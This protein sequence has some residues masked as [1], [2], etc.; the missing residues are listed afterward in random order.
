M[1]LDCSGVVTRVAS[2]VDNGL[3]IG[4]RVCGLFRGHCANRLQVD[5][6][7]M[8]RIPDGMDFMTAASLPLVFTTAYYSLVELARLLPGETVLIHCGGGG[9]G[10]AAIMLAKSLGAEVFATANSLDEQS[11][12]CKT[13]SLTLGHVFFSQDSSFVSQIMSLTG[14]QGVEVI[15]NSLA[16][17]LLQETWKCIAPFGRFVEIGKHDLDLNHNLEMEPF[18]RNVSFMSVDMI[19]IAEQRRDLLTKMLREIMLLWQQ[20]KISPVAPIIA[21]PLSDV[22]EALR[23]LQSG[24]VLGK[25]CLYPSKQD[26]V[27]VLPQKRSPKLVVSA[28][29]VL[30]GGSGG[31]G[32][33]IARLLVELGS[34][35]LIILSRN[36]QS[37][38]QVE[39]YT[40]LRTAGCEVV[41][42]NCDICDEVDLTHA[43]NEC[44]GLPPVRG[45]IQGAMVLQ[46]SIFERMSFEAYEAA[47]GSKVQGSWNLHKHFQNSPLDFFILLSSIAAVAGN[48][49]QANY[50]A[51]G[52]F[53][54]ALARYRSTH[55]LPAVSLD[56]GMVRTV[57]DAEVMGLIE[58]AILDPC[59]A[60]DAS[61]VMIGIAS[62]PGANWG[63]AAWR[64]DP[65]F[66]GLCPAQSSDKEADGSSLG[67]VAPD[68]Q[69]RL[70]KA[71][72][73]L[74]AVS[75]VCD[76]L[77]TKLA[78]M[79]SLPV[80]DVDRSMRLA[81]Y[82]VDSFVAVELRNWLGHV[83]QAPL[84]IFD[85]MQS[86]RL[87][88]LAEKVAGKSKLIGL[89]LR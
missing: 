54:D 58:G 23:L 3:K 36:A 16:G 21:L 39:F 18:T 47:V 71:P 81:K 41:A 63:T 17:R 75:S 84:S 45:V 80:K 89:G 86:L 12:L 70:A 67:K 62:G 51:G 88:D 66:A 27:K 74:E 78:E 76:T 34:R 68:I 85:V 33:S 65:R 72:S 29:Y 14:N 22:K 87:Q 40:D 43:L 24:T 42:R 79:F 37:Q 10:Q 35:H 46:D 38:K 5:C 9:V 49:S 77:I 55:G 61:Q 44:K 48:S 32:R 8:I 57:E 13:Y 31:L 83:L 20:N 64:E 15:L 30:I 11:F 28:S 52:T 53:Q 59:C 69:A 2:S 73:W 6:K 26:V 1:R 50:A 25:I 19:I 4:D 82:G 60:P 56:L 7:S